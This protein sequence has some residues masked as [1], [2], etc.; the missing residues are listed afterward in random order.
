MKEGLDNSAVLEASIPPLSIMGEI[1]FNISKETE[2]MNN[3]I[4]QLDQTS[5]ESIEH[6]TWQQQNTH[7]LFEL[8]MEYSPR[9]IYIHTHSKQISVHLKIFKSYK[10]SSATT[11]E[12]SQKSITE[13]NSSNSQICEN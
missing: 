7:S 5:I 11:M 10:V 1:K 8:H 9:Y 12:R 3:T 4:N 6:S 2:N 13:G